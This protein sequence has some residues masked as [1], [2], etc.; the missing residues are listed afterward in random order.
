[1]CA[2]AAETPEQQA[3]GQGEPFDYDAFISYAHHDR[4]VA[5]GIQKGLHRIGRR[6]G[7]L[8]ALRVFRD[9][10]DL[11][12]SPNLWGE[13]TE[14]MD[15]ARYFIVVLSPHA[16]ASHW[17]NKEVAH[18]LDRR[19]P[20]QLLFVVA[21][22]H[23][24]WDEGTGRFDPDRSD[25]ALP[26]LEEPGVLASEPFYVDVSEDEPWDPHAPM[27]REKVT[28][29][30]API[31]GKPKYEL[32][33]EDLREQRRFRRLRRAAI[34][35][36]VLLTVLA[37]AAATIAF[38]QQQ[39]AERQ[40]NEAVRQ[41]N[42]A[43]A[44]R[45]E[46]DAE[47]MLD[48][49]HARD[50]VRA[51]QETLAAQQ[52]A[53]TP[54]PGA[55]LRTLNA[56]SSTEKIIRTGAPYSIPPN[57][58]ADS[59][60]RATETAQPVFS[61]AIRPDGHRIATS[62]LQ[63]RVWDA[64]TGKQVDLS[65]RT[66]RGSYAVAYS[67]DGHRI[68][69]VNADGNIQLWDADTGTPVGDPL[70]GHAN[71]SVKSGVAFSPD[72][73]RI[74]SVGTDGTIRVWDA[75][76]RVPL[77]TFTGHEGGAHSVAFSPDGHRMVSGGGDA[78]VRMWDVDKGEPIGEPMRRHTTAVNS[79]A[80]SADGRRIV[81]GSGGPTPGSDI[82]YDLA[83]PIVLWDADTRQPVGEPLTGHAGYVN[84][85]AFS[86]DSQRIVSGGGDNV[87]LLWDAETGAS[88]GPPL[89][90]HTGTVTSVAFS[91]DKANPR[92]VSSSIDGTLRIWN[93]EPDDSIGHLW[94]ALS[95]ESRGP[96]HSAVL[97][98]E[99]IGHRILAFEF[100]DPQS[101]EGTV[102]IV[103]P[104][105]GARAGPLALPEQVTITSSAFS[106]DGRR[107]AIG[108]DDKTFRIWEADS[109]RA[110]GGPV[111]GLH[112]SASNLAFSGD[113]RR[114]VAGGADKSV[115][116]W[117]VDSSRAIGTPLTGPDGAI[118]N[119]AFSPDGRRVAG[120]TDKSVWIWDVDS[121]RTIGG[122]LE[123]HEWDIST[124]RFG[125]GGRR[126]ISVSG[127]SVLLWDA[128]TGQRVAQAP[129]TGYLGA[130]A[131][132]PNGEFFVTAVGVDLQRWDSMTGNP[133]GAP[134]PGRQPGKIFSIVVTSDARYILSGGMD[135]VLRFWDAAT[136]EPIGDPLKGPDGWIMMIQ[137]TPDGRVV[138]TVWL[139]P[140]QGAGGGVWVW[141]G[142]ASWEDELCSKLSENMS[143]KQW[144]E[145]V[146]PDIEYTAV[147]PDLPQHSGDN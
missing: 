136:G 94:T 124:V 82:L 147:C 42:Q 133:I 87:V 63:T 59:L 34:A 22:G 26:V 73:H 35:G 142:P 7:H 27:F 99:P 61:I 12:A 125:S 37:L 91:P 81:S 132:S 86:P 102:W 10:T 78:T 143:G 46:S 145:W 16:V 9:A 103:D 29:L 50:D 137:A 139:S 5:A 111:T 110:L 62:G 57:A 83:A 28:D 3:Q 135:Q 36:L 76:S 146:S 33:S 71:G 117:D 106:P 24:T 120:S 30:A 13:V 11:T 8:H 101:G 20:D 109:G 44:L 64:N 80:F 131:I 75:E 55:A 58:T 79:V 39:E 105:T 130:F 69:T 141:P 119:V 96:G 77:V 21:D 60:R 89:L 113:G 128:E 48:G 115:I 40:R 85:V 23:L 41:R 104:D 98:V 118:V 45:L 122:P 2:Q 67:P 65:S 121:G 84:S 88:A 31:H 134:M 138:R 19:G 95:T 15:R 18:W 129:A 123:G 66:D 14:A 112:D 116:V 100:N 93:T 114:I 38:V 56:L 70:T 97:A 53:T 17:V 54:N 68:A 51:I 107:V 144:S 32:A 74:A 43:I 72:G 25:V 49:T 52:I 126:V 4:P 6:M 1:M 127:D 47:S 108:T 92:I 90:G 140:D